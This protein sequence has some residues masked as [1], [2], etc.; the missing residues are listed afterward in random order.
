MGV[1]S[2]P[3]VVVFDPPA[4]SPAINECSTMGLEVRVSY[5]MV[6]FPEFVVVATAKPIFTIC[7]GVKSLFIMPLIPEVP[8]SLCCILFSL[9]VDLRL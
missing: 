7:S 1:G 2:S 8:K 5:A 4:F 9:I 6:M 3:S